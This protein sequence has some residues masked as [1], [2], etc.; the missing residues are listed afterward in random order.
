M[1]Y[2]CKICGKG[3]VYFTETYDPGMGKSYFIPLCAKHESIVC[4]YVTGVVDG[5]REILERD[6]IC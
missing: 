4:G 2:K 6:G 5:L 1:M 3:T